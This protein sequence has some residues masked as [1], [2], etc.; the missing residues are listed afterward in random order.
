MLGVL[1]DVAIQWKYK[2]TSQV[3]AFRDLQSQGGTDMKRQSQARQCS[4]QAEHVPG[5][6]VVGSSNLQEGPWLGVRA[7]RCGQVQKFTVRAPAG[8]RGLSGGISLVLEEVVCF[9]GVLGKA[10]C[11]WSLWC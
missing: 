3:F 5:K 1:W 8:T 4:W 2:W 10:R 9:A 6:R 11:L 7:R